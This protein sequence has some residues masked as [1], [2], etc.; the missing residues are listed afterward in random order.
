MKPLY[1]YI[2]KEIIFS[3]FCQLLVLQETLKFFI[4]IHIL[5]MIGLGVDNS[6]GGRVGVGTS[7]VGLRDSYD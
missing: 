4:E 6:I 2:K 5:L 7:I 3:L 1:I